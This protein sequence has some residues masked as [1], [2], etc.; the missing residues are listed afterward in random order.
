MYNTELEGCERIPVLGNVTFVILA[1]IHSAL[2][3]V[4]RIIY[5]YKNYRCSSH[6]MQLSIMLNATGGYIPSN[7]DTYTIEIR[8]EAFGAVDEVISKN[9]L[10]V[11]LPPI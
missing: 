6:N 4:I 10:L 2:G 9:N 1:L 7:R 3:R 11:H 8:I 5:T